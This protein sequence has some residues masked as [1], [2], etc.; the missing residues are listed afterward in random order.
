M[1]PSCIMI[2]LLVVLV[3]FPIM[4][5]SFFLVMFGFL[6]HHLV[7]KGLLTQSTSVSFGW[8]LSLGILWADYEI[9]LYQFLIVSLCSFLNHSIYKTH[10]IFL[11]LFYFHRNIYMRKGT[12]SKTDGKFWHEHLLGVNQQA[13]MFLSLI[14]IKYRLFTSITSDRIIRMLASDRVCY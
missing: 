8:L 12:T 14:F 1:V 10:S 9:W 13:H 2:V 3:H 7:G 6:S 11:P 4:F 5:V